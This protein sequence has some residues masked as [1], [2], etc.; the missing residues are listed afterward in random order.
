M[1]KITTIGG[2]DSVKRLTDLEARLKGYPLDNEG[3]FVLLNVATAMAALSGMFETAVHDLVKSNYE[4]FATPEQCDP[5]VIG[6]VERP[7]DDPP[8]KAA[9]LH[10][11]LLAD[12]ERVLNTKKEQ[13]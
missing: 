11:A 7:A 5:R 6:L 4:T 10:L 3:V 1:L 2:P 8:D 12:A 13:K 9:Q